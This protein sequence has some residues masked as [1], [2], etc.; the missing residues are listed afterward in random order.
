M[1][2][3]PVIE[4]EYQGCRFRTRLEARWAV[5]FD[6]CG[7]RWEYEPEGFELPDGKPFL[8]EFL[9]HG[10]TFNHAD[11]SED[12]DLFVMVRRWVSPD[13]GKEI[14]A[15]AFP[16]GEEEENST[17]RMNPVLV[18][19]AIPA[20]SNIDEVSEAVFDEAYAPAPDGAASF[21][22]ETV[23]GDYF[24]AMPGVGLDGSFQ[25]FGAGSGYIC[26][27]DRKATERAYRLARQLQFEYRVTDGRG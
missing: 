25:L 3:I 16:F 21:N 7:V 1:F 6:L 9:L 10:V 12:N 11:R 26:D 18:V 20:G 15:F 17:E 5:F 14:R 23:D 2:P 22:F 13:E 8:P 24:G 19:G 27:M 4:T